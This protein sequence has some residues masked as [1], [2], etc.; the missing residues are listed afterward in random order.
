[1]KPVCLVSGCTLSSC[2]VTISCSLVG[3]VCASL[4]LEPDGDPE[5]EREPEWEPEREGDLEKVDDGEFLPTSTSWASWGLMIL[6]T[7]KLI[8]EQIL[9]Y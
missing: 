9:K 8:Y 4:D 5:W 2:I 7:L 3:S 6:K 1:M